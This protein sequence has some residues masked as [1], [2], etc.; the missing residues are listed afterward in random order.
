M[1]LSLSGCL[2]SNVRISSTINII[3]A[4]LAIKIPL[5]NSSTA[6]VYLEQ[7]AHGI[8]QHVNKIMEIDVAFFIRC[9]EVSHGNNAMLMT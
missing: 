9:T 2:M 1:T 8:T 6:T 4:L 3:M 5:T 7:D